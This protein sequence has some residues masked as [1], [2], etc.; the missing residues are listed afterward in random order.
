MVLQSPLWRPRVPALAARGA[1]AAGADH[2]SAGL[3]E[4]EEGWEEGRGMAHKAGPSGG[5]AG[6]RP[7]AS[8]PLPSEVRQ[9]RDVGKGVRGANA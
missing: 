2:V 1:S 3:D 7:E 5:V 8:Q 4:A 6:L 9:G